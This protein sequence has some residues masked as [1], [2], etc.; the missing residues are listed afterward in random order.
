MYKQSM[1]DFEIGYNYVRR[2]FSSLI[3]LGPK[4]LWELGLTFLLKEGNDAELSKGMAIYYLE[5]G[6]KG[7]L[8]KSNQIKDAN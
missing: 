5:L 2:H 1:S 3:Q 4:N 6:I 7:F 8:T